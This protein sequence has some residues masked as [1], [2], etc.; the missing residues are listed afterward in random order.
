MK[1]RMNELSAIPSIKAAIRVNEREEK[2]KE[3][4]KK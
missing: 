4:G 2:M 1:R 3:G